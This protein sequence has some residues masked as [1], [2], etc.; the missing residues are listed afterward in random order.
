MSINETFRQ[1]EE[2]GDMPFPECFTDDEVIVSIVNTKF[3]FVCESVY[4]AYP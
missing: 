2:D 4:R 3:R 1:F